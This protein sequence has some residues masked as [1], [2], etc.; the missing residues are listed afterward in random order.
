MLTVLHRSMDGTETVFEAAEVT[1]RRNEVQPGNAPNNPAAM[2]WEIAIQCAPD[3]PFKTI[4]IPIP[5]ASDPRAFAPDLAEDYEPCVIVM[6]HR[7][8]TVAKYLL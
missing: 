5:R 8:S 6:N 2:M 7:G 3:S 4:T 1:K